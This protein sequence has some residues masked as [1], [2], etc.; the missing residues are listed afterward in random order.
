MNAPAVW[1]V[2]P[3][4]ASLEADV[5]HDVL[6]PIHCYSRHLSLARLLV[7][8]LLP[9][10]V[11]SAEPPELTQLGTHLS[12]N[13][14]I[15]E[16][17]VLAIHC[18]AL[19]TDHPQIDFDAAWQ[20]SFRAVKSRAT[21]GS[22]GWARRITQVSL[23]DTKANQKIS[24]DIPT[25]LQSLNGSLLKM[26]A[27]GAD[28]ITACTEQV[29]IGDS[30]LSIVKVSPRLISNICAYLNPLDIV[31]KL[32]DLRDSTRKVGQAELAAQ[33]VALKGRSEQLVAT[34][35]LADFRYSAARLFIVGHETAH[36]IFEPQSQ[37]DLNNFSREF[38][39]DMAASAMVMLF[40]PEEIVD[41]R[42]LPLDNE[43]RE[44]M[45][46][47]MCYEG[48]STFLGSV[49]QAGFADKFT[50]NLPAR[51]RRETLIAGMN[52]THFCD[53][54]VQQE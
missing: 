21:R 1:E 41:M 22:E 37:P 52:R 15:S 13:V 36:I 47:V 6:R 42:L 19:T 27:C 25:L 5:R 7:V 46:K 34:A 38:R 20:A 2:E 8:V 24:A 28:N 44:S 35:L 4:K 45:H 29:T 17:T 18:H 53:R 32:Q 9:P 12:D 26:E 48:L 51:Q 10:Q 54:E 14:R 11:A 49:E 43:L 3:T 40:E 16:S 39:A 33:A 31:A 30:T 50:G 23:F